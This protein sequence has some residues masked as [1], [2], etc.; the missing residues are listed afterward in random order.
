M[1]AFPIFYNGKIL[2]APDG[3][4]AFSLDCCCEDLINTCADCAFADDHPLT[5]MVFGV[6][7]VTYTQASASI[8]TGNL[9]DC[10][11]EARFSRSDN[12][13]VP[14]DLSISY[15]QSAGNPFTGAWYINTPTGQVMFSASP[16]QCRGV[17][18]ANAPG[19]TG[20]ITSG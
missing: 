11:W 8:K 12:P 19:A 20:S 15:Q 13:G 16:G 18:N 6:G 5:N 1:M 2:F 17:I 14:A 3:R 10:S 7:G 4:L 9:G